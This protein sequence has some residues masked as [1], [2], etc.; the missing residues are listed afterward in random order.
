MR[1]SAVAAADAHYYGYRIAGPFRSNEG[2]RFDDQ[3]VLLDPYARGCSLLQEPAGPSPVG[4]VRMP[5][6]LRRACFRQ[7]F[8]PDTRPGLR[9]SVMAMI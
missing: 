2:Q 6:R 4:L 9:D 3:K 1:V 5:G 7:G 8:P